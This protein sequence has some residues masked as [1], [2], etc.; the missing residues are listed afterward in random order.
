MAA[1]DAKI[2]YK[3]LLSKGFQKA[4][5]KSDDHMWL[6]FWY[7]GKLTRVKTKMS[8]SARDINDGLI[9]LMSKQTYLTSKQFKSMAECTTSELE[10]IEILKEKN[11]VV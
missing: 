3:N 6:E 5:N 4:L 1:L 11:I 9:S 10:Y 7:G 2:T 8:H